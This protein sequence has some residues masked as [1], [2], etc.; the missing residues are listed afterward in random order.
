MKKILFQAIFLGYLY[1]NLITFIL[2]YNTKYM[3]ILLVNTL[4]YF[5]I[6]IIIFLFFLKLKEHTLSYGSIIT[7]SRTIINIVILS[8][9]IFFDNLISSA[10]LIIV[11][12]LISLT[13]DGVDGYMAKLFNQSSKFGELF[14]M[15][16]DTLL[17]FILCLSLYLNF[18][19]NI[20]ILLIPVYRYIFIIMQKKIIWCR[21][22]LPDS[23]RRKFICVAVTLILIA[24]HITI[25]NEKIVAYMIN[26]SIFLITFS[27]S[28]DIIWLY[29]KNM[30]KRYEY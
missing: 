4:I 6:S 30:V 29:Q 22:N 12:S 20:Y 9:A 16:S 21:N 1:L 10:N 8:V 24:S 13:L 17:M 3:N 14:D 5:L 18:N 11:L 25:F 28:K 26:F 23:L 15:E 2:L 27:F 7:F 19:S